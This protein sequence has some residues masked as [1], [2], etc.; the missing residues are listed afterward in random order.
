MDERDRFKLLFGPYQAPPFEY[1]ETLEC[2]IRGPMIVC[3]LSSGRIA[4]P[5]GK[6]GRGVRQRSLI[7]TGGL[8]EAIRREAA[9]TVC[10]WW[11]ISQACVTK[12]RKAL[13]VELSNEGT[14]RLRH[15][16]A[17]EPGVRGGLEKARI[18]ANEPEARAKVG[19]AHRGKRVPDHVRKRLSEL[20]KGKPLAESTRRKI[21]EAQR[22][23]IPVWVTRPWT[24]EEDELVRTMETEEVVRR[25]GRTTTAV[26]HR[27]VVLGVA[28]EP[29]YA[30]EDAVRWTQEE[31][32]LVRTLPAKK[33]VQLTG[34]NPQAVYSRRY[35]LGVSRVRGYN[36]TE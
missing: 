32:E 24:K 20:R 8:A 22:G 23:R 6:T 31:D 9:I 17:D 4:W 1:G 15:E 27:R 10:Y 26:R 11:G 7:V 5:V 25:T 29:G 35:V 30:G 3:K 16:Y 12:W 34:R 14:H 33:V 2:E 21:S 18:K 13:G 28:R 36:G 19:A